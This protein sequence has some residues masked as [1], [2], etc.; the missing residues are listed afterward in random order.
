V[1]RTTGLHR[2]ATVT[3]LAARGAHRTD[4]LPGRPGTRPA[5]ARTVVGVTLAVATA[6]AAFSLRSFL[7]AQSAHAQPGPAAAHGRAPQSV[8]FDLATAPP[9]AGSAGQ[10]DLAVGARR[11]EPQRKQ[12][13]RPP[14]YRNPLRGVSGLLL[15]RVDMGADFAGSGPVYAIGRAVITNA[16]ADNY[17]WP[18]A[19]WITYELT[20]GPARGLEVYLAE[21]VRPAV[22]V[23]QFVTSATMIGRMFSG[24]DGIE[25]GWAMPDGQSAESQLP[26]AGGISGGGPFPT[27]VGL[28]FDRLLQALGVRP[29]PNSGEP[30]YGVLPAFYPKNWGSVRVT[31]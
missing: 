3:S 29:A 21:D 20:A 16:S 4:R 10:P 6:A 23:G 30:G 15:E 5:V 25:T 2:K 28:D 8:A 17:G 19:G 14:V 13:R 11:T 18:G 1:S 12:R 27:N 31:K 24:G 7:P 9:S 26:V 22:R